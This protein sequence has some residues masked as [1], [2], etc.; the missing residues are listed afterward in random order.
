MGVGAGGALLAEVAGGLLA[1]HGVLGSQ[2]GGVISA[3]A[4][5]RRA[6]SDSAVARWAAA[7]VAADCDGA[8]RMRLI[9]SRMPGSR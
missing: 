3:R 7:R 6:R 2:A 9:R 8:E 5:F 1:E 4:V